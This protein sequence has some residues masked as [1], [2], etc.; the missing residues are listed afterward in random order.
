MAPNNRRT[1]SGYTL[2]EALVATG[3]FTILLAAVMTSWFAV[4][5]QMMDGVGYSRCNADRMRLTDYLSRDIRRSLDAK[6]FNGATPCAD[7]ISGTV[8]ELTMTRIYGD[9]L[10]EDDKEASRS[11]QAP[12]FMSGE[13]GYG[14]TL[15]VRYFVN[16]NTIIRE[17]AGIQRPVTTAPSVFTM[18]F[19]TK[20]GGVVSADGQFDQP[21]THLGQRTIRRPIKVQAI[22]RS[23]A[24]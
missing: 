16:N 21:F 1:V 12:V 3:A 10:E 18:T 8:L 2:V 13:P 14:G 11:L 7:G 22:R 17:E 6:V 5:R 19:M 24:F 4:Q 15:T 9:L 20:P 23:F